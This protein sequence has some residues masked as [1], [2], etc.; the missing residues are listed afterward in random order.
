[1]ATPHNT[2]TQQSI[3]RELRHLAPNQQLE[4]L[5]FA[6]FLRQQHRTKTTTVQTTSKPKKASL[7]EFVGLLKTSPNFNNDPLQI[8]QELRSEWP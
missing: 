2:L 3:L 8:Q 7:N 4:V 6:R 5:D 1:M